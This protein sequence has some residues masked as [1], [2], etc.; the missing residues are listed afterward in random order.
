MKFISP[1]QWRPKEIDDLEPN[2]WNALRTS[3]SVSVIAGPGAGKTEFLA[4]KAAYL[5]ETGICPP[6]QQ[7]LA[8]SFK[9]DAAKNLADR[10]KLRCTEELSHRLVSMTFDAFTKSLV[11]RFRLALPQEW[12]PSKKY[13]IS[14]PNKRDVA[15][16]WARRQHRVSSSDARDIE[17]ETRHMDAASFES[18][19]VGSYRIPE[20]MSPPQ[21]IKHYLAFW[22]LREQIKNENEEESALSFMTINRLAEYIVR[23]NIHILRALKATY[24]FVF[25]DEFQDTTYGQ[26][27]FLLSAFG[28]AKTTITTVGDYKQ[29]IM[30]WAGAK[31]DAFHQFEHDFSATRYQLQLNHRSSPELVRLQHI[32]AREIEHGVCMAH[33]KVPQRIENGCAFILNSRSVALE[34]NYIAK[35]ISRNMQSRELRPRDYAILA[36][37]KPEN[38]Y[39][40]LNQSLI[41]Y[42]LKLRNES[43]K[44][45]NTTLQDLLTEE[46]TILFSNL[47]RFVIGQKEPRIWGQ[48]YSSIEQLRGTL[49]D[50]I[51]SHKTI[52]NQLVNLK[53]SM[54]ALLEQPYSTTTAQPVLERI[55][56][57][58]SPS[59]MRKAFSRYNT[60]DLLKI[61]L[62][63]L[64]IHF[65]QYVSSTS[66]RQDCVDEFDGVDHIPLMTI[67][68]S[69]GLEFDTVIFIGLDDNAW[70]SHQPGNAESMATFFVALSRAKQRAV[71][72]FCS[73]RGERQKLSDIYALLE[74][75]GVKEYNIN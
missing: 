59:D 67:H 3:G 17:Y 12:R 8:I 35:W 39:D 69:K 36:R 49:P 18:H 37:Q 34:V 25:V 44:I 74:K 42:H 31:T 58:I 19:V 50:D 26:Y 14:Y 9:T 4:Q 23:S 30:G 21:S 11:D 22:W 20:N 1:E 5:L 54:Q 29:R 15:Q 71:F 57:F 64:E 10:V 40:Q 38:Y 55:I 27:D 46:F 73:E 32:V 2:A 63:A 72:S 45:G 47:L 75:S 6:S 53:H 51:R 68:K 48:V 56:S 33:T 13:S 65:L 70:W 28:Q 43:V 41:I 66:N 62:E 52:E 7:I 16:F 61:T 60:G 24:P